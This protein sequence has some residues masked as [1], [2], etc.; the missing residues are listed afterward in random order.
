M[1][2]DRRILSKGNVLSSAYM[3]AQE[4]MV[5]SEKQQGRFRFAK[6]NLLRLIMGVKTADQRKIDK[7]RVEVGMKEHLKKTLVRS[8]WPGHVENIGNEKLWRGNGCEKDQYCDGGL[9]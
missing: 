5:L 4:T 6:N 7:M 1:V 9:H 3:N 8:T 2:E